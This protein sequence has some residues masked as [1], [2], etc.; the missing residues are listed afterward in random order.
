MPEARLLGFSIPASIRRNDPVLKPGERCQQFTRVERLHDVG[1][2][3]DALGFIGLERFHF[4]NGEQD[5]DFHR[6]SGLFQPLTNF[7]PAISRHVNVEHDEI[8]LAFVDFLERSRAV[9][10]SDDLIAGVHEDAA[11]HVLGGYAV[12]GKQYGARQGLSFARKGEITPKVT[13]IPS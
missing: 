12:I 10:D 13:G 6:L 3:P 5:G 8:R 11:T 9:I 1:I 2:R 7:K 4:S